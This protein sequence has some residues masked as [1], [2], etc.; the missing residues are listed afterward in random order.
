MRYLKEI[1]KHLSLYREFWQYQLAAQ[2]FSY[3][4]QRDAS[5]L[6]DKFREALNIAYSIS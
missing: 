6:D 1:K 5:E 4:I 2:A 3:L